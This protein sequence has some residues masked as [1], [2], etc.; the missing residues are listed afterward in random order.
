MFL[1]CCSG[2]NHSPTVN[3]RKRPVED[4][5][6]AEKKI[7]ALYYRKIASLPREDSIGN[8]N[9]QR[10]IEIFIPQLKLCYACDPLND[11]YKSEKPRNVYV[12]DFHSPEA[13]L[14]TRPLKEEIFVESAIENIQI[15]E[16]LAKTILD[17]ANIS[18][19]YFMDRTLNETSYYKSLTDEVTIRIKEE[20]LSKIP[21]KAASEYERLIDPNPRRTIPSCKSLDG[22]IL[23]TQCVWYAR[24]RSP[25]G[26]RLYQASSPDA[27]EKFDSLRSKI[28]LSSEDDDTLQTSFHNLFLNSTDAAQKRYAAADAA[29]KKIST[30]AVKKEKRDAY[31]NLYEN[32]T[33]PAQDQMDVA[34]YCCFEVIEHELRMKLVKA[35]MKLYND[36]PEAAQNAFD[37]AWQ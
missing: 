29:V 31:D 10:V 3:H 36:A 9:I 24:F 4:Y 25:H 22:E 14:T 12:I 16:K 34:Y 26:I 32:S 17:L 2:S 5:V 18:R 33:R 11:A 28:H 27:R 13:T 35:M 8:Q 20:I 6:K 1:P 37:A 7:P 30:R 21:A 23:D 15:S 19:K